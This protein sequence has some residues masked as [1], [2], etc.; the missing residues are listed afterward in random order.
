MHIYTQTASYKG[1]IG[2]R[3]R[4]QTQ[5][6]TT[7]MDGSSLDGWMYTWC[8]S[9]HYITSSLIRQAIMQIPE[10]LNQFPHKSVD[11][12]QHFHHHRPY[13]DLMIHSLKLF[14]KPV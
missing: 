9:Q 11:E 12:L 6:H 2:V 1:N 14:Y 13:K 5:C 4:G 7:L 3:F 10:C 8:L